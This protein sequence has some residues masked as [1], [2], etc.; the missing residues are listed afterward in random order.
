MKKD[1]L[2]PNRYLHEKNGAHTF[3]FLLC[4]FKSVRNTFT[5]FPSFFVFKKLAKS[6]IIQLIQLSY[7]LSEFFSFNWEF[8]FTF[9]L[10]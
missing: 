2:D 9:S 6:A 7:S 8:H 3:F 10:A 4:S 1:V 5:L